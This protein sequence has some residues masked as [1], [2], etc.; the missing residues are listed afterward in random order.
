MNKAVNFRALRSIFHI[1]NME[2]INKQPSKE[3]LQ[4]IY[5]KLKTI[6]KVAKYYKCRGN[7]ISKLLHDYKIDIYPNRGE[8]AR[9][10]PLDEEFFNK[11]N[12]DDVSDIILYWL[13][14]LSADGYIKPQKGSYYVEIQLAKKDH[15]H[16][17]LFRKALK[18]NCTYI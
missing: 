11:Y 18:F 17:V 7:K 2:R 4:K 12:N 3:E 10:H 15:K 6:R 9:K 14:F 1:Q 13:G 8:H 16:I 5:L